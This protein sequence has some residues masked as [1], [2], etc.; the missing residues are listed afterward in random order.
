MFY[1]KSYRCVAVSNALFG[2]TAPLFDAPGIGKR[3]RPIT[4]A[5]I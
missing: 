4:Q 3:I 2:A 1:Q 5:V